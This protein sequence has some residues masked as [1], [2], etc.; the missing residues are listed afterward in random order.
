MI[1]EIKHEKRVFSKSTEDNNRSVSYFAEI[2]PSMVRQSVPHICSISTDFVCGAFAN[3]CAGCSWCRT[4]RYKAGRKTLRDG[5][6]AP[7]WL[8]R[9]QTGHITIATTATSSSSM[10][11][12]HRWWLSACC[13]RRSL[14]RQLT[15]WRDAHRPSNR[16]YD[17][18]YNVCVSI[19]L[20]EWTW[21]FG[22]KGSTISK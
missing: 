19:Y 17:T 2:V 5:R 15:K 16:Q 1:T 4:D 18:K 10:Q 3:A 20:H 21:D 7:R 12:P 22:K 13:R 9:Q 11:Q 8:Q 6:V 14:L